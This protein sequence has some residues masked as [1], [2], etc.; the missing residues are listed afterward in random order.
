MIIHSKCGK[1][2]VAELDNYLAITG[3]LRFS[4][5]DLSVTSIEIRKTPGRK[6]KLTLKCTKCNEEI[7]DI[8]QIM[9]RCPN[10]DDTTKPENLR[11]IQ[12]YGTFCI[13][14]V[15]RYEKHLNAKSKSFDYSN[16]LKL[17]L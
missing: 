5:E 11:V 4:G 7:S 2:L 1:L 12:N 3:N 14:C 10:C 17:S 6:P 13:G 15:G 16:I 8:S 9:V